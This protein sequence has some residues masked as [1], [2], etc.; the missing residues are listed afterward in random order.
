MPQTPVP[1]Y[2]VDLCSDPAELEVRLNALSNEG[3]TP[4]HVLSLRS[5]TLRPGLAPEAYASDIRSRALVQFCV[6]AVRYTVEEMTQEK[7]KPNA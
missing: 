7:G 6:V 3:W 5:G 4:M 2:A 1:V